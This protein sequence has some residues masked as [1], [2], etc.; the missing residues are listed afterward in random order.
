MANIQFQIRRGLAADWVSANPVLSAG[1]PGF[2]TDTNLLK[3][4]D[5][6]TSWIALSYLD[7]SVLGGYPVL[8]SNLSDG[9]VLVYHQASASWINRDDKELVDGGNF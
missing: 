6:I 9:D 2:E 3:I 7:S 5:G 8:F 1:E 4:G